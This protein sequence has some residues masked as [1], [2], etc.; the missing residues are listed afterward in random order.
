[1]YEAKDLDTEE[2]FNLGILFKSLLEFDGANPVSM[3]AADPK[4]IE[5]L[6]SADNKKYLKADTE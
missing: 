3:L 1:M 6:L 4:A 5:N 2:H